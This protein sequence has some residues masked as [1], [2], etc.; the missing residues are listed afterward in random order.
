MVL[1]LVILSF[2]Q[3]VTIIMNIELKQWKTLEPNR[4][5]EHAEC[6]W[7]QVPWYF[8]VMRTR[9]YHHQQ[10]SS[11]CVSGCWVL[12]YFLVVTLCPLISFDIALTQFIMMD[13]DKFSS[14]LQ[15]LCSEGKLH[16]ETVRDLH[17]ISRSSEVRFTVNPALQHC[18]QCSFQRRFETMI[19]APQVLI[20]LC[21]LTFMRVC[22]SV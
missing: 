6:I 18:N 14:L 10:I 21:Q 16:S 13:D 7:D 22:G 3:I 8:F 12:Q 20:L 11:S 15:H 17:A 2:I 9:W 1:F 19:G 5:F 4:Q